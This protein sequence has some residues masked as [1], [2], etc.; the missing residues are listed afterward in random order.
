MITSADRVAN[1]SCVYGSY[2][3]SF[4]KT[5]ERGFSFQPVHT[6]HRQ[7]TGQS[8]A[9]MV[10]KTKHQ[11]EVYHKS[12]M[13]V[14]WDKCDIVYLDPPY[15]HRQYGANYFLLNYIIDYNSEQ[16]L[17][18][19]TGLTDYY[20]SPFCQKRTCK[21][22]FITLFEHIRN[23]PVIVLSYNNEGILSMD[24]LKQILLEYGKTTLYS[25]TYKKFKAQESVKETH[26]VEYVWVVETKLERVFEMIQ[27]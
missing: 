22:A 11:H 15:N 18:G 17:R 10:C 16:E 21:D 20:K 24:D 12:V 9:N 13:D 5:A 3:K 19:K 6:I 7:Y 26:V 8:P 14:C 2:L 4:K 1:I 27:M 23:V 25:Y